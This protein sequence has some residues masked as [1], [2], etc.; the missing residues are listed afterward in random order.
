MKNEAYVKSVENSVLFIV[1]DVIM[2]VAV[3]RAQ[4]ISLARCLVSI[5]NILAACFDFVKRKNVA[6]RE[7]ANTKL[8]KHTYGFPRDGCDDET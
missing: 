2:P 6:I 4:G 8:Y 1:F 3:L 5:R 7:Q